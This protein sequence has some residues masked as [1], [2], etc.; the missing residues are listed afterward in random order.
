[1][2]EFLFPQR[3]PLVSDNLR[4][5]FLTGVLMG[6]LYVAAIAIPNIWIIFQYSGSTFAV[7]VSLIFPAVLVLR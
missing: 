6:V 3:R 7:C 1:M 2:D 5:L 4:F